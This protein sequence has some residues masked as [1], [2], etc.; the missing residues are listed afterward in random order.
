MCRQTKTALRKEEIG[1]V[2]I[3]KKD[4][5]VPHFSTAIFIPKIHF[6]LDIQQTFVDF[7]FVSEQ[8]FF[9]QKLLSVVCYLRDFT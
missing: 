5:V 4:K 7:H 9:C 2:S 3:N 6:S 8:V 1:T